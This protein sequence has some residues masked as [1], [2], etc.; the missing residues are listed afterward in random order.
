MAQVWCFSTYFICQSDI[1]VKS[2]LMCDCRQMQHTVSRTSQC[3]IYSQCIHDC[4][5]CHD[6][7]RT[8]ILSVHF[9]N[10]HA[11]MFCQFDTL[12]IYSR[13]GSVSTKSHTQY[14]GQAV[15]TV[16]CIHTGTG[17]AGRAYFIFK[18]FHIVFCHSSGCVGSYCLEHTGQASFLTVY[19]TCK[20]RTTAD[21]YGRYVQSGCCHQKSRYIFIT[22]WHHNQCIELM[23]HRHRFCGISDQVTGYQGIFHSDMSHGDTV[24][25]RN[26]RKHD[27]RTACHGNS[28]FY[29]IND[30]IQIHMTGN[31]LVIRAYDT[32]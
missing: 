9:H 10:L 6:I 16:G 26:R 23:G 1:E 7:S 12:G 30:F 20:H 21:K 2:D 11:G 4:F 8:D 27:R 29:C 17:T 15:H 22:V 25:D 3:H 32:D 31:D 28:L 18:F 5:F 24:T 13:D 14:L 19:M